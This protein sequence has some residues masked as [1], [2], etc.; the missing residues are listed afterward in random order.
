MY[1]LFVYISFYF[2]SVAVYVSQM[3]VIV[4]FV[5]TKLPVLFLFKIKIS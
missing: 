4:G 2:I 1:S 5:I 3:S